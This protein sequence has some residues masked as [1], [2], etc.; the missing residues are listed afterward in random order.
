[1]AHALVLCILTLARTGAA[2]IG[3]DGEAPD[4]AQHLAALRAVGAEGRGNA[5]ASRA[6]RQVS[7]AGATALP[8]ILAAMDGAGPVS[9]NWLRAAVEAIAERTIL[10][11]GTL[12]AEELERFVL[13]TRHNPRARRLAY[14]WLARVDA[15]APDR[16]IPVLGDDPSVELR[17]DAVE[18]A[19]VEAVT[20]F[21]AGR[22]PEAGA[23]YRRALTLARDA[24]QIGSIA[25]KLKELGEQVDLPRHFGFVT[26]WRLIGPFDNTGAK[27]FGVAYPPEK[28]LE[29]QAEYEGKGCK[30]RWKDFVSK[31]DYGVVDLNLALGKQPGV[32]AYALA[33]FSSDRARKIEIRLGCVTAWKL[34]VNG[35]YLFGH[36]EY[37][38]GM[39]LDQ[40]RVEA[41][42][43]QG[44][45]TILLK[46]CQNEQTEDWAQEW[47]F[48]LRV[49][50]GA[51]TAVLPSATSTTPAAPAVS[52]EDHGSG[53]TAGEGGER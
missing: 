50:D 51:G 24:D 21:D 25:A 19:L 20:L 33:E 42:L 15:K 12:P 31:D 26:S 10:A 49:C 32:V 11:G 3:A 7:R 45:N 2:P 47:R 37:H 48:Q 44:R 34:W 41:E 35:E 40:F 1:M 13:D 14:E 43:R 30:A 9:A 5:D 4:L 8:S 27:A 17:R 16:I 53:E 28:E 36:E 38:H 29:L 22:K 18:R 23:S 39:E 52:G 46:V 6:W